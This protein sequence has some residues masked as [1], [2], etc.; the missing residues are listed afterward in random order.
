MES[1]QKMPRTQDGDLDSLGESEKRFESIDIAKVM[2]MT[3]DNT[4]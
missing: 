2:N 3:M 1:E 4:K